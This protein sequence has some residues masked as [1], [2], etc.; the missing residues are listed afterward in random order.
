MHKVVYI[1]FFASIISNA[2]PAPNTFF[3]SFGA[4]IKML[5][6]GAHPE[7]ESARKGLDWKAAFGWEFSNTRVRMEAQSFAEIGFTKWTYLAFDMKINIT[8]HIKLF[9]GLETS[10]IK[11][12]HPDANFRDPYN[13]IKYNHSWLLLGANAEIQFRI[14]SF[15]IAVQGNLHQAEEELKPYKKSRK[16]VHFTVFYFF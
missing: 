7:R 6:V 1:L 16:Q 3:M 8:K 14:G 15:G 10:G 11:R 2:Q 9:A 12:H 4:D 5:T 13:Y